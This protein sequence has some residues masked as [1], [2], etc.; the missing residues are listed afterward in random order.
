MTINPLQ[1]PYDDFK[2]GDVIDSEQFDLNNLYIKNTVNEMVL[3]L[4]NLIGAGGGELVSITPVPPYTA[5][6]VQG[7]LNEFL[8]KL[9]SVETGASGASAINTASQNA[10]PGSTVEAQFTSINALLNSAFI[11]TL[12][13]ADLAVTTAKLADGAVTTPKLSDASVTAPKIGQGAVVSDKIQS[14]AVTTVKLQNE[15]VTTAKIAPLSV[16]TPKLA[17]ANVTTPKIADLAVTTSKVAD[18]SIT[19]L[20]LAQNSV[21]TSKVVDMAITSIK[22]ALASVLTEHIASRAVTNDKLAEASVTGNKIASRTIRAEN[23]DPVLLESLPNTLL[24]AKVLTLEDEVDVLQLGMVMINQ[25]VD[26]HIHARLPHITTDLVANKTYR[27]GWIVE[28][29]KLY[30]EYEEVN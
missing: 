13:I 21:S 18:G 27:T 1:I 9:A 5:T 6:T 14:E 4:N 12:R 7:F 8:A 25:L 30:Y 16:T 22:L 15:G 26:E 2:S 28:D 17:D 3:F 19:N 23:L 24:T 29:G 10:I 11:T 20:K